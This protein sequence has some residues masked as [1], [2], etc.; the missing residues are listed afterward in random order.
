MRRVYSSSFFGMSTSQARRTPARIDTQPALSKEKMDAQNSFLGSLNWT[1]TKT[2]MAIIAN[3][4][5]F[6][7]EWW[8]TWSLSPSLGRWQF[9]LT[10]GHSRRLLYGHS[11]ISEYWHFSLVSVLDQ[12]IIN[13][14]LNRHYHKES[15]RFC[16]RAKST[17]TL[18]KTIRSRVLDD[19]PL[20]L[21]KITN[22]LLKSNSCALN[23]LV[24]P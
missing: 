14:N 5:G 20:I 10:C 23:K 11:L 8:V 4:I 9:F 7:K 24:C 1:M 19:N 6:Q 2:T 21:T 22:N 18:F 12:H 17:I 3:T 13:L 15:I 16:P